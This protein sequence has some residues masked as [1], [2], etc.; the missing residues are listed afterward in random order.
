MHLVQKGVF[1]YKEDVG[2]KKGG[3]CVACY[4]LKIM[5]YWGK[6]TKRR[7]SGVRVNIAICDDVAAD[8][9]EIRDYLL[10]Y[11]EQNG[12]SGNIRLFDSGEALLAAFEPGRF[13]VFFLDIFMD[14]VSGVDAA[15]RIR[16]SDPHC[17]LVFI[18]VS[19]SHMR[20][21]FALR[22]ASYVEKPLTPEKLELAFA[23][24]RS[25][26]MKHARYIE[27][28]LMQRGFKVP[29]TGLIY[30]EVL[31]KSVFF[32]TSTG[33]TYEARM[34]MADVAQQLAGSPFLRCHNS[35]IVNLNYV[36]TVRGTNLVL[37]CG[38][39]IPIRKNGRRA[40]I[41]ALNEFL[42]ERLFEGV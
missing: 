33:E 17:L 8:A 24:C 41:S 2:V 15:R 20:D 7:E 25:L 5:L 31:G 9:E 16:E 4:F 6:S 27:I 28:T 42:S 40:V 32:H 12:F 19:D 23:Q 13:D 21:G 3:L 34:K 10:A 22:A 30:A 37:K 39:S 29:F 1:W 11:F 14:G 36:E 38:R 35:Y 18:T 26:F